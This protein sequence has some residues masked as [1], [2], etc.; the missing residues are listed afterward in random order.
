MTI[1]IETKIAKNG[2][3]ICKVDSKRVKFHEATSAIDD[4]SNGI[5]VRTDYGKCYTLSFR[6]GKKAIFFVDESGNLY[7]FDCYKTYET[8]RAIAHNDLVGNLYKTAEEIR[9]LETADAATDAEIELANKN[10]EIETTAKNNNVELPTGEITVKSGAEAW[11][12]VGK[13]FTNGLN[14]NG[15][16]KGFNREDVFSYTNDKIIFVSA[17]CTPDNS[18]VECLE[19][20]NTN[21]SGSKR[22]VLT[23]YINHDAETET[24]TAGTNEQIINCT[25]DIIITDDAYTQ[26]IRS[27]IANAQIASGNYGIEINGEWVYFTDHKITHIDAEDKLGFSFEY[28]WQGRKQFRHHGRVVS[29]DSIIKF[30]ENKEIAQAQEKSFRKFFINSYAPH[31]GFFQVQVY[32]TFA[33]NV[34]HIYSRYFNFY[35]QAVDFVNDAIKFCADVPTHIFIGRNRQAGKN[36][37]HRMPDGTIDIDKPDTDFF[38]HYSK[39]EIQSRLDDIDRAIADNEQFRHDGV[40]PIVGV[41][42]LNAIDWLSV[43]KNFYEFVLHENAPIA[44]TDGSEEDDFSEE[45]PALFPDEDNDDDNELIDPPIIGYPIDGRDL[46]DYTF[47]AQDGT[48]LIFLTDNINITRDNLMIKINERTVAEYKTEDAAKA[49][50]EYIINWRETF[51]GDTSL[52]HKTFDIN[53]YNTIFDDFNFDGGGEGLTIFIPDKKREL[54]TPDYFMT[55]IETLD[56]INAAAPLGWEIKYNGKNFPVEFNCKTVATLDSLALAK[57]L[58]PDK[59]F[60][61]FKPDISP[62]EQFLDDRRKELDMLLDMRKFVE[63]DPERLNTLSELIENTKRAI[64]EAELSDDEPPDAPPIEYDEHGNI[65]PFF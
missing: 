33:D 46:D 37:Y 30:F 12:I 4:I 41:A 49:A 40:Q 7:K 47:I 16:S 28:T 23:V 9:E 38:K 61:Q 44:E 14:T 60:E 62:R 34:E 10:A 8:L 42:I 36:Y 53:D 45:L 18:R 51:Y 35:N 39:D 52:P 65:I 15:S 48:K 31:F 19:V 54:E 13:H 6:D 57:I 59:F 2:S 24:A 56:N 32:A 5:Q 20:I 22:R 58:P 3:L 26:M 50:L 29:R 43:I 27:E 11:D 1:T 64:I 25:D 55:V 21:E 63:D 17:F